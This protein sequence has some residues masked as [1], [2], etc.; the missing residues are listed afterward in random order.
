M[1]VDPGV[2]AEPAVDVLGLMA[3]AATVPAAAFAAELVVVVVTVEATVPPLCE[4]EPLAAAPPLSSSSDFFPISRE[5]SVLV[6]ELTV[7]ET[8]VVVDGDA[9]E[10]ELPTTAVVFEELVRGAVS[11]LV[12]GGGGACD[13]ELGALGA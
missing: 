7:E 4:G 6:C 11:S 2:V 10:D 13:G 9:V 1:A 5:D 3:P 8:L 12:A